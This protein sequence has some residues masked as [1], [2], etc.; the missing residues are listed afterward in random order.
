MQADNRAGIAATWGLIALSAFTLPALSGCSA[1]ATPG[2]TEAAASTRM[3]AGE[4]ES[5][6][7][8]RLK[9]V[10]DTGNGVYVFPTGK[11]LA[12]TLSDFIDAHPE[13]KLISLTHGPDVTY[14][15]GNAT[16]SR[17]DSMIAVFSK[18]KE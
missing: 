12:E 8:E 9:E 14:H 3:P 15:A 2:G 10:R 17:S 7:Q 6:R 13:L 5:T 18:A 1:D 11:Y 4:R 16:H